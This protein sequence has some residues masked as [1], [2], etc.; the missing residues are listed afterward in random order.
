MWMQTSPP[1]SSQPILKSSEESCHAS[2]QPRP[3][4]LPP[5]SRGRAREKEQNSSRMRLSHRPLTEAMNRKD[6]PFEVRYGSLNLNAQA[7]VT[8][9]AALGVR[10]TQGAACIASPLQQG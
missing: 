5:P 10:V 7:V 2:V 6:M 3:H 1:N 4:P 8:R 9:L